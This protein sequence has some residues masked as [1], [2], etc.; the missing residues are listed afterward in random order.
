MANI[1]GAFYALGRAGNCRQKTYKGGPC[2]PGVRV[3]LG[4]SGRCRGRCC[5]HW[6]LP[7]SSP[8]AVAKIKGKSKCKTCEN[9]EGP[10]AVSCLLSLLY[11]IVLKICLY[12]KSSGEWKHT[13]WTLIHQHLRETSQSSSSHPGGSGGTGSPCLPTVCGR[14]SVIC[15]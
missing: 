14:Q 10:T 15:E 4:A 8:H 2:S 5:Y 13:L 9:L 11:P 6:Y 1:Y 3:S 7:C 12:R